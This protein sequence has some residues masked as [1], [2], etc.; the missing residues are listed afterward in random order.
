MIIRKHQPKD[1]IISGIL[2]WR[3]TK[4]GCITSAIPRTII[5]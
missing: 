5:K 3:D 2:G 1:A 4:A